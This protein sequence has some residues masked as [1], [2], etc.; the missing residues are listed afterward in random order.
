[1]ESTYEMSFEREV[2]EVTQ[3]VK[4]IRDMY[5]FDKIRHDELTP[6]QISELIQN[7]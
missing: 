5:A 6:N 7:H 1:M 4:N 3:L 2:E